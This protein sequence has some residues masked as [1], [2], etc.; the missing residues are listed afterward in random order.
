MAAYVATGY[1]RSARPHRSGPERIVD[2]SVTLVD[3]RGTTADPEDL[4]SVL[5]AS[6][7]PDR[8]PDLGATWSETT[9]FLFDP[10]SWR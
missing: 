4:T 8:R 5:F 9:F 6:L 1:I 7:E 2:A 3:P 10:E